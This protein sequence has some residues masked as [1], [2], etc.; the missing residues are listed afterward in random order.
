MDPHQPLWPPLLVM[1]VF[2]RACTVLL[3]YNPG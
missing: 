3:S 2:L 1:G